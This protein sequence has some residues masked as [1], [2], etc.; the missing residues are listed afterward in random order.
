LSLLL[1]DAVTHCP[2]EEARR[3]EGGQAQAL[4]G[5][6]EGRM[7]TLVVFPKNSRSAGG[8]EARASSSGLARQHGEHDDFGMMIAI[9]KGRWRRIDSGSKV[10]GGNAQGGEQSP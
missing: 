5:P 9:K 7:N 4:D 8:A 10:Q 6:A 3:E 1:S 2:G